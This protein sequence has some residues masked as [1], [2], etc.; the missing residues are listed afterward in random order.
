M[1]RGLFIPAPMHQPRLDAESRRGGAGIY[2]YAPGLC[3]MRR[4]RCRIERMATAKTVIE[5]GVEEVIVKEHLSAALSGK[6]KLRIKFGIDPTAP[7]LHLGHLVPLR[8]LH[9]FQELSHTVVLIIGDFT[10]TIGD[11]SGRSETRKPLTDTEVR[12]NMSEYLA[13]AGKFL[14]ME[15]D[16]GRFKSGWH[17]K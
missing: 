4:A 17:G 9:Q 1:C 5:C 11:P 2:C 8:K 3:L 12:H 6:K 15:W 16:G 14:G 13:Q 10:A 7:Q